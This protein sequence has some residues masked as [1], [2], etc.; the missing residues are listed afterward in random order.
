MIVKYN[1]K[2]DV[3]RIYNRVGIYYSAT[4]FLF[5]HR[6]ILP[7][8]I[9]I[10]IVDCYL[11]NHNTKAHVVYSIVE[12]ESHVAKLNVRLRQ[13]PILRRYYVAVNPQ[14][15]VARQTC[16]GTDVRYLALVVRTNNGI[17]TIHL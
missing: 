5:R 13:V 17:S 1:V 7:R 15:K 8:N 4:N 12:R 3:E 2:N 10:C 16:G 6:S 14:F 9:D 11:I